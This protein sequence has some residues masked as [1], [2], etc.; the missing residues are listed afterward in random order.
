LPVTYLISPSGEIVARALGRR[1]WKANSAAA[2]DLNELFS[3]SK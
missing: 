1:D 3:S 2:H